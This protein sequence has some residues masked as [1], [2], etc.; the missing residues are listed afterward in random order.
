MS[1]NL[2]LRGPGGAEVSIRQAPTSVTRCAMGHPS[3]YQVY[4]VWLLRE[5]WPAGPVRGDRKRRERARD[6]SDLCRHLKA[7]E[8]ADAHADFAWWEV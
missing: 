2:S 5:H 8:E 6:L 7:V 4:A 3:P 1:M